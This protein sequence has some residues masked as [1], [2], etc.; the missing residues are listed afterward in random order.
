[1]SLLTDCESKENSFSTR[2]QLSVT[3]PFW[4][5]TVCKLHYND[6]QKL[7]SI[8]GVVSLNASNAD[9]K[10]AVCCYFCSLH[11]TLVKLCCSVL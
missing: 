11:C 6:F 3:T 9:I 8:Y 2:K 4:M 1:M 10:M 5:D 7:A